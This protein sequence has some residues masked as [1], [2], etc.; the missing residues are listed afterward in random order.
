MRPGEKTYTAQPNMHEP[1]K[2]PSEERKI[3]LVLVSVLLSASC[4]AIIL[5]KLHRD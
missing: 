4:A 5:H 1:K 2:G 3:A